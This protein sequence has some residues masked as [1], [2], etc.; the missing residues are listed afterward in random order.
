MIHHSLRTFVEREFVPVPDR[1]G[2][3]HLHRVVRFDRC[4]VGVIDLDR[5]LLQGGIHV[6]SVILSRGRG[7]RRWN[8]LEHYHRFFSLILDPHVRRRILR[9][10]E[11][12][13]YD[14]RDIL[15]VVVDGVVFKGRT[16]FTRTALLFQ[17]SRR[18]IQRTYIAVVQYS[19]HSRH[20]LRFRAIDAL[21]AALTDG[22]ENGIPIR[23]IFDP[24][25]DGILSASRDLQS[26]VN[27]GYR[28]SNW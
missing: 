11:G 24:V 2:A 25:L 16:T 28:L 20:L 18:P 26:A 12:V 17:R 3:V 4:D 7:R 19:Q 27:P 10:L 5:S 1:D 14:Q 13:R 22:A 23:E 9:L 8:L 6:S 15:P 21:D